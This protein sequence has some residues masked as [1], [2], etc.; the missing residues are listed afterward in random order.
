MTKQE[1]QQ[2]I[3]GIR[4][5]DVF[6]PIILGSV[7]RL[8]WRQGTGANILTAE[9]IQR[10]VRSGGSQ[11]VCAGCFPDAD[12]LQEWQADLREYELDNFVSD[13]WLDTHADTYNEQFDDAL[14]YTADLLIAGED[15]LF[16]LF[17][18]DQREDWSR[19]ASTRFG[20]LDA[21]R[22]FVILNVTDFGQDKTEADHG[23]CTTH[24]TL[25]PTRAR[26]G[27]YPPVDPVMSNSSGSI[28][29]DLNARRLAVVANARAAFASYA[30]H[31]PGL[32]DLPDKLN[33]QGAGR[34]SHPVIPLFRCCAQALYVATPYTGI[35]GV[36]QSMEQSVLAFEQA[37]PP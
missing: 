35:A 27:L 2:F 24:I 3:T 18:S 33:W 17:Q 1:P 31:D 8:Q 22:Q 16:V 15:V 13:S 28:G 26:A 9:I 11:V 12:H 29:V 5:I 19:R 4:V 23:A 6:A 25:D 7:C 21:K 37:M 10:F 32:Q 34:D 20:D 14:E 30:D 36:S